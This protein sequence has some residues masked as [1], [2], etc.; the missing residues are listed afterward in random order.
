M[1]ARR[2]APR[3]A[4]PPPLA[5]PYPYPQ[6]SPPSHTTLAPLPPL[7]DDADA[8]LSAERDGLVRS[9]TEHDDSIYSLVWSAAD[10]WL[11]ASL[12]LDGRLCAHYVPA[13]EKYR[14]L[15]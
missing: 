4:H 6:P 11:F 10:A 3:R 15:L 13:A 14:I 12:S 1:R 9:L 7:G 8:E 2:P 5:P